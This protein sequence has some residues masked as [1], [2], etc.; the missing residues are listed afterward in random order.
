MILTFISP[1]GTSTVF[2]RDATD[3]RLLKRYSGFAEIPAS[4]QTDKSPGQHGSTLLDTLMDERDIWFDILIQVPSA[5]TPGTDLTTSVFDDAIFD[6]MIFDNP[7]QSNFD[8]LQLVIANLSRVLNPLEGPGTLIYQREDGTQYRIICSGSENTVNLDP[9]NRSD[10]HQK[11]TI[12]LKAFD[13]FWYSGSVNRTTFAPSGAGWIPWAIPWSIPSSMNEKD[14]FNTGTTD[15]NVTIS[16]WGPIV[17]PV[18]TNVTIKNGVTTT[19]TI[20]T[21]V[22]LAVNDRLD[23]TTGID[24]ETVW[25]TVGSAAPVKAFSYITVGSKFWL[26]K[27]GMNRVT[28]SCTSSTP[29][30]GCSISWSDKYAGVF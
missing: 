14:C 24:N 26:M 4:F 12:R 17:E 5:D 20:T 2:S 6:D 10:I 16:I 11:A 30:C 9:S 13:P 29:G 27:K 8:R 28:L 22:T 21:S 1:D 25:L 7:Y 15:T 18:L 23:I 3:Y 19:E